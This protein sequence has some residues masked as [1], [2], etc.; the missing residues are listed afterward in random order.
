[1]PLDDKDYE[2]LLASFNSKDIPADQAQ[3]RQAIENF[4]DL[5][6]F[7]AR[8][9]PQPSETGTSPTQFFSIDPK[10]ASPDSSPYQSN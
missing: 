9:L 10:F 3:A 7:L 8:P 5:I 6:E 1:M 2:E 4:I